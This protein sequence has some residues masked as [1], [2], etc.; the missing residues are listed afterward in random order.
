MFIGMSKDDVFNRIITNLKSGTL[1]TDL[2]PGS[3]A[4]AICDVISEEFGDFYSEL[5]LTTTMGFVSTAKGRFLDMTGSLLNCVRTLNETDDNYRSRIVNQVYV[6][7]G[8]N[9]TSIRLKALSIEGVKD[10]IMKEFTKGTGSFSVYVI[11]DD[12]VT[13][14]PILDAVEAIIKDNKAA[15]IYAEV[16]TPVLIPIELK[17]RLVFSDTISDAEKNSIRQASRQNIKTYIDNV[18]LGGNFIINEVVT[19]AMNASKKIVDLDV[20]SLTVNGINQYVKNFQVDWDERI[21]ASTLE[22]L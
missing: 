4:R 10:V 13:P 21:V 16:K 7:A 17:V 9:E 19:A 14:Q 5:E 2:D 3:I 6:V 18:G 11:T 15:G 22:V 1:V 8:A 12:L 20:V